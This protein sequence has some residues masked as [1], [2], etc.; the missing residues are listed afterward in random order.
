MK[1]I[2]PSVFNNGEGVYLR[3]ECFE[4]G[5]LLDRITIKVDKMDEENLIDF[6]V[7]LDLTNRVF[8]GTI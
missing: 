4:D 7:K 6:F 3:L 8:C 5:N 1:E 2:V